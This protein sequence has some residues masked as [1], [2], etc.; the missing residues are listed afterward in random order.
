M[1][2]EFD[3]AKRV[4]RTRMRAVRKDLLDRPERSARMWK[5][6]TRRPDVLAASKIMVRDN[7][8]ADLPA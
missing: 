2:S 8:E 6:L 7:G 3:E 4:L 5:T 1:V